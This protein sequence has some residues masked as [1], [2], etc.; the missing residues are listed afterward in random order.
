MK[1]LIFSAA[2][3]LT[4]VVLFAAGHTVNITS[5]TNV[6]CNGMCNGT[7][8]AAVT[9]GVGPFGYSW[10]AGTSVSGL[11]A[12]PYVLTVTDSSDMSTATGNFVIT[13]PSALVATAGGSYSVCAGGA[14]VLNSA[15]TGGTPGYTYL[16][17]P[18]MFL[19]SDNIQ[20]PVCAPPTSVSY[21]LTVTDMNGC[22]ANASAM[23]FVSGAL[24][25]NITTTDATC[26]LCDGQAIAT[27]SGGNPPYTYFWSPGG[28]TTPSFSGL[29][30]GTY[31]AT[32][33]DNSGCMGTATATV[34]SNST[35]TGVN[36]SVTNA[37]CG[38]S[39]GAITITS[40]NGGT[41]P[42]TYS[43]SP[44]V[45]TNDTVT[46]LPAGTYNLSV[47]DSSG[48]TY[49]TAITVINA[50]APTAVATTT[51]SSSCSSP[52]GQI[53]IGTVTGGTG[54]YSYSLNGSAFTAATTYPGL[55]AGIYSLAVQDANACV[56]NTSVAV[57]N[58][59]APS[60]SLD[61][62]INPSCAG[63]TLGSIAINVSG[64]TPG[65]TFVWNNG[66]ITQNITGVVAGSYNVL[67]TDA[68]GC[69]VNA[70]FFV[71]NSSSVYAT[72]TS[73]YASCGATAQSTVYGYGGVPPYTY[74]WNTVPVQTTQ[75]A[76]NL[77]AGTY[78]CT[79]T[80]VNGCY[81]NVYA[82]IYANCYNVIKGRIYNDINGNCIQDAGELGI[83]GRT[84]YSSAPGSGYAYT[85]AVGDYT[86]Y[87]TSMNNNVHQNLPLYSTQ[88]CPSVSHTANFTTLGDTI[89]NLDFADQYISNVNDL[90]V[91]YTAGVARPGFSQYGYLWYANQGTTIMNSV[92]ISLAHDSILTYTSSAPAAASYTYPNLSW[93]IGTLN[94][95][96]SGY[97]YTYFTVPT[98]GSGGFLGRVLNYSVQIDPVAGDTTPVNNYSNASTI[99]IG[100]WDPN[101]KAVTPAGNILANDSVLHY[102]IQFQNTGTDTAFTIVL[103]DTLSQYLDPATVVPGIASHP[104]AFDIAFNGELTWT[105]SNILLPDSN[106]NE[107]GS[108]G[109]A[110][111]TVK[112]RA[113]N[114][115]GTEIENTAHIYFDYNPAVVT[116][117]VSNEIV[118]LTTGI[119]T[120]STNNV[121]KV[122]PNPFS[123]NTTFEIQSDKLNEIYSFEMTDVLGKSVV[124]MNGISLKKFTVSRNDLQTGIY[125]YKIYSSERLIGIGK[126][127]I[128]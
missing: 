104:Y 31:T 9:G 117:T 53:N 97:I 68:A 20:Y 30:S 45:S 11:C 127:I 113:N 79:I 116:N 57:T 98:I 19:S 25:V 88:I 12:G 126:L 33:T 58:S 4:N 80:D 69:A 82:W 103:K 93:N 15:A 63:G 78:M 50:G 66:A 2:L 70:N 87:T 27:P 119:E 8:M 101:D 55:S 108:H 22:T 121:V 38:N 67:V 59:G 44:I 92:T 35:I 90:V 100:S 48:C 28:F 42:F 120:T 32:V 72:V 61:S 91:N 14:V 43:W 128:K 56:F 3:V 109:F 29:C 94:P 73:T 54:P 111:F 122:Y 37:S 60:V 96:Q 118:D 107:P 77:S 124:M 24:M 75:T 62:I 41:P 18:S 123:D 112:Q 5:Q 89:M 6:T 49:S 102:K 115:V 40:V 125:F 36:S 99:I 81:T 105:F 85:N 23:V 47:Y 16:W 34:N 84:V 114:P 46:G 7:A 106:R 10:G 51:V 110:E 65:Y 95:G 86:M 26:G 39:D 17:T 13:Q 83:S 52:T 1:K 21:T 76:T 74:S 64:G 71:S